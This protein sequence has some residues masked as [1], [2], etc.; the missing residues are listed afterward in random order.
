MLDNLANFLQ[1]VPKASSIHLGRLPN[2]IHVLDTGVQSV[3]DRNNQFTLDP[4]PSAGIDYIN[5]LIV[6]AD[7]PYLLKYEN[8]VDRLRAVY[9]EYASPVYGDMIRQHPYKKR[10][11]I[12]GQMIHTAEYLAITEDFN[13]TDEVPFGGAVDQWFE[14]VRPLQ[15]ID[16]DSLETRLDVVNSK[17]KFNYEPPTQA[18]FSLNIVKLLLMYTKYRLSYPAEF[19]ERTN[20]YPFIY[21]ACINPLLKDCTRVYLINI[22]SD[23]VAGKLDNPDYVFDSDKILN[24]QFSYFLKNNRDAAIFE[25]QN[26][27][28]KCVAGK[29]KPDELLIALKVDADT[30]LYDYIQWV[31]D[32]HYVGNGGIQFT[33][34]EFIIQ[35]KIL[36]ILIMIY[37]LQ[38]D[39]VRTQEL[40]RLFRIMANRIKNTRFWAHAKNP[41]VIYLLQNSF[42]RLTELCQK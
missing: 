23:M 2:Y 21:R 7:I 24:S 4:I 8:D 19:E 9:R 14:T 31:I 36:T 34:L 33:W 5:S 40:Y 11:F 16:L 37:S 30:N 35:Y 1:R 25:M 10:H 41:Q 20:N 28:D 32:N 26:L 17:I 12:G 6:R 42:Q 3:I 15:L 39:S 18:V 13:L 22:I 29:V 27:I 38:P